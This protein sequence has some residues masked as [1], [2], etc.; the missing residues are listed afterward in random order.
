MATP[1][2]HTI[3]DLEAVSRSLVESHRCSTAKGHNHNVYSAVLGSG[4]G[5]ASFA[6]HLY[7]ADIDLVKTESQN[8]FGHRGVQGKSSDFDVVR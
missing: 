7:A 8:I 2:S 5:S 4:A 1:R 6:D 3:R